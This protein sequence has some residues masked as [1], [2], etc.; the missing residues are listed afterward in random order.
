MNQIRPKCKY[1][2]HCGG[3]D[4]QDMDYQDQLK[5]KDQLISDLIIQHGVHIQDREKIIPGSD[6]QFFYRNSIR[7]EFCRDEKNHLRIARHNP[8]D[9]TKPT[10]TDYCLLQS[11]FSNKLLSEIL[12]LYNDLEYTGRDLWQMKIREGKFTGEFMF[13]I[14]TQTNILPHK[15][16]L[17][18]LLRKFPELK[19]VYQTIASQKDVY[20]LS[21]RLILGRPVIYE[22][23]GKYKFQISP[24]SFFQTN[25][26]G[27]QTLYDII[28]KLADIKVG[29]SLLDLYC[30]T[31]SI[32]I[33]LSTLAKKVV[34]VESV[35]TAVRDAQDNA[36]VNHTLNCEFAHAEVEKYLKR[37]QNTDS[38]VIVIDPPRA[39][40]KK[41]IIAQISKLR[42]ERLVYVSCNPKTFFRDLEIFQK[43]GLII[44]KLQPIDMFPQ[45]RHIEITGLLKKT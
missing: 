15:I 2:G 29:E 12:A 43:S 13:E 21:R 37:L 20:K 22:K 18:K 27:I 45:T 42:C 26:L 36:R 35:A 10:I 34:G 23:I 41:N 31:G 17:I 4:L 25:S 16:E 40:L 38:P 30:G 8:E 19:S 6:Q 32:G 11:E 7:F 28:K 5:M 44:E 33:Y 39:G 9:S 1:F 14:I 3:C 24:E